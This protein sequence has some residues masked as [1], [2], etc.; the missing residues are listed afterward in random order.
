MFENIITSEMKNMFDDA[1]KALLEQNALTIPCIFRYSGGVNQSL[2]SNCV[3]DPISKRSANLYNG[4]GPDAFYEGQICPVC[5]G[6]GLVE[7][8]SSQSVNI[9]V[10]F[11]S[12][13]FINAGPKGVNIPDGTIQTLCA[14][15]YMNS[16]KNCS[17]LTATVQN[18]LYT[19][20]RISEPQ[21]MGFGNT[22]FIMTMWQRQ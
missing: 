18:M 5:Q 10:I 13:Y 15:S 8:D 22:N 6:F 11:D 16:I 1:I 14:S 2:C 7:S 20:K 3:F 4:T 21:P 19:Y 12:K 9:A 17:E